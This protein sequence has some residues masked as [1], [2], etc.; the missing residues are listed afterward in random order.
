[1]K[2]EFLK[3]F[4]LLIYDL[5]LQCLMSILLQRPEQDD[6]RVVS[7]PP[8]PDKKFSRSVSLVSR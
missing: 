1:M 2:K 3:G 7:S 4:G 5:I 8:V 6:M